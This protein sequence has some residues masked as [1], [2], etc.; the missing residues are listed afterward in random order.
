[1][2]A[3]CTTAFINALHMSTP[4]ACG[5]KSDDTCVLETLNPQTLSLHTGIPAARGVEPNDT[6]N[7]EDRTVG[8][9]GRQRQHQ[10]LAAQRHLPLRARQPVRVHLHRCCFIHIRRQFVILFRSRRTWLHSR[11]WAPTERLCCD[12]WLPNVSDLTSGHAR[13]S[14]VAT[15][16]FWVSQPYSSSRPPAAQHTCS[17]FDEARLM[18]R[19]L[20]FS[21]GAGKA[22]DAAPRVPPPAAEVLASAGEACSGRGS[23]ERSPHRPS[24]ATSNVCTRGKRRRL[25][26]WRERQRVVKQMVAVGT[27][28]AWRGDRPAGTRMRCVGRRLGSKL[29][30]DCIEIAPRLH[31]DC[32]EIAHQHPRGAV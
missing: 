6:D 21:G 5:V 1:M 4:A 7:L 11:Q 12:V 10:V 32:I 19:R 28:H 31:R 14:A 17:V 27:Q 30:R 29:H 9:L 8:R 20:G 3:R 13:T 25:R 15:E 23:P 18:L 26:A 2:Q 16:F 24:P 22:V